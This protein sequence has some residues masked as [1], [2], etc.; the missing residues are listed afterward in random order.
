MPEPKTGM[1]QHNN[2]YSDE[3]YSGIVPV[4]ENGSESSRADAMEMTA[5]TESPQGTI[6]NFFHGNEAAKQAAQHE[7]DMSFKYSI[8][9]YWPAMM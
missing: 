7:K 9:H 6:S 1:L 4:D 8:R 2:D 5:P 3:D